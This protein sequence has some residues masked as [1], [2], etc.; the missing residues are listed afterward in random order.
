M[1]LIQDLKGDGENYKTMIFI[2]QLLFVHL[3]FKW[4]LPVYVCNY[5]CII[6]EYNYTRNTMYD[7][8]K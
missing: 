6:E 4:Y 8:A 3:F 2:I 1:K 5:S 7:Y